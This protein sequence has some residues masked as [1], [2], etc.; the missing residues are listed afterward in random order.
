MAFLKDLFVKVPETPNGYFAN[1]EAPD[2]IR[3]I[4]LGQNRFQME[5]IT[6]DPSIYTMYH[7]DLTMSNLMEKST[8]PIGLMHEAFCVVHIFKYQELFWHF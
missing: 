7:P 8:G 4:R 3:I 5:T 6:C 2:E 1:S